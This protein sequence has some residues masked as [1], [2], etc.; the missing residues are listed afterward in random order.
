MTRQFA[1]PAPGQPD[2]RRIRCTYRFAPTAEL[3]AL[4]DGDLWSFGIGLEEFF[5]RA[6]VLPGFS[7]VRRLALTPVALDISWTG[8]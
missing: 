3:R 7:E 6:L 8:I 5:A 4:G 2:V 1:V